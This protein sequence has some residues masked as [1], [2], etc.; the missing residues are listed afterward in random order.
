MNATPLAPVLLL[1][2]ALREKIEAWARDAAPR[3]AG[4]L[5]VGE[6]DHVTATTEVEE[7]HRVANLAPAERGDRFEL[8]P[9]R[10]VEIEREARAA[11]RELVG[12]WH[13]HPESA[14]VLS[15]RD[16]A[17][18]WRG[19]SQLVVSLAGGPETTAEARSFR[20]DASAFVEERI[21]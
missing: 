13:S 10:V 14:A 3:E 2:R 15:A 12:V 6:R 16:R 8:D 21:V 17:A 11:G 1:P 7:V 18:A 20:R 19:L 4:G 9:G 5:L